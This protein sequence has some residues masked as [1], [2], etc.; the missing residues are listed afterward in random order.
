MEP[1]RQDDPRRLGPY[2]LVGRL[3]PAGAE[4]RPAGRRFLG[5]APGGDRTALVSTVPA[6]YADDPAYQHRFR[7][8]ALAAQRLTAG[9]SWLLPVTEAGGSEAAPVWCASP[10]RPA[11]PLPTVVE[12]HGPLPLR[13]VLAVG[14]ALAEALTQLHA[15]GA[16]HAGVTADAVLLTA[17][18][19]RLTGYGTARVTAPDGEPRTPHPFLAPEQITGGRPRPLGDLYALATVL[20]YALTGRPQG[21]A[22]VETADSLPLQL[23]EL[24]DACQ[25]ADPSDRPS[26]EEFLRRLPYRGTG[27]SGADRQTGPTGPPLAD[28]GPGPGPGPGARVLDGGA[29]PGGGAGPNGGT[30]LDSGTSRAAGL[31]IPGWLPRRVSAALAVQAAAVLAAETEEDLAPAAV[32]APAPVPGSAPLLGSAS[33]PDPA[34]VPVPTQLDGG[35]SPDGVQAAPTGRAAVPRS[36]SGRASVL[37]RRS[38]LTAVGSGAAG[39]AVGGSVAW[40]ATTEEPRTLSQ[41]ERLASKRKSHKRL[42]GAPP[43]PKWRYDFSEPA[44][45]FLPLLW[46]DEVA[47]L[48]DGTAATGIEIR[49]GEEL[50]SRAKTSP[51]GRAWPLGNGLVLLAGSDDLL[52]L[53][54]RDGEVEWRSKRYRKGGR[55]PYERVLAAH[56]NVIWLVVGNGHSS[57]TPDDRTVAA[58]DLAKDRELWSA[59]LPTDYQESHLLPDALVVVTAKKGEPKRFTAFNR[60]TG[61]KTW[62]RAYKSVRAGQFT[63]VAAPATLVAADKGRLHGYELGESDGKEQWKVKA[64]DTNDQAVDFFGVPTSHKGSVYVADSAYGAYRIDARTGKV[65]WRSEAEFDLEPADRDSTPDTAVTPG[66]KVLVS[67]G[68]VEV[69]AYET[70]NGTLLWRFTDLAGGKSGSVLQRRRVVLSDKYA[71]VVSGQSAYALPLD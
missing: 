71:L 47:L 53:N 15:G 50:W 5:L 40:T 16:A 42:K 21:N 32:P 65:T 38:L 66:G 17:D 33:V 46:Q 24:L 31:L 7:T 37:S 28:P 64:A 48:A 1:L 58:Y 13:T 12:T 44:K 14:T 23:T 68:E 10:Y 9:H 43:T 59:P 11:L 41:A 6:Q 26:A 70:R 45:K 27:A 3:D 63:T 39:V 22:P 4:I 34:P 69:D 25:A 60:K 30:V 18:G 19:P 2:A 54:P 20:H 61:D 8:E 55:R 51:S 36:R 62:A 56:G 67:A 49:T 29:A 35:A 57:A 52:A